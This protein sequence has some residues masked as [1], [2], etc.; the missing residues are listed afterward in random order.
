MDKRTLL[1][2]VLS[3]VIISVGFFLQGVLFPQ[4]KHPPQTVAA[5]ATESSTPQTATQAAPATLS[6]GEGRSTGT[7]PGSQGLAPITSVEPAPQDSAGLAEESYT[8][9]TNLVRV[10]FTSRGGAVEKFELLKEFDN[11]R[12]LEMING[13]T[14]GMTAFNLSFGGPNGPYTDALFHFKRV[15][16]TTYEFSRQFL[17]PGVNGQPPIPFLLTKTYIFHPNS[18]MLE[19]RITIQN[20]VNAVPNLTADG[21]AYTLQF[22]PQIGPYFAKMGENGEFRNFYT[23]ADGRRSTINPPNNGEKTF[24]QIVSWTSIVGKYFTVIAIP[25]ATKYAITYSHKPIQGVVE[26]SQLLF[27]R[28]PIESS[29]STSMFQFYVGPKDPRILT[30]FDDPTKN[31]FHTSGLQLEKVLDYTPLLG[32]LEDILNF[33]LRLFHRLVPNWGVSIIMLTVLIKLILYPFT[34][35]SFESTSKM[36]ALT[37]KLNELRERYKSNPTKLNQE[38]AALYKREGVSPL[39]GC[40]PLILQMPI[41]FALYGLLNTEFALRGATFIPGWITDLSQPESILHF[42]NFVIP[43]LGWTDLRALPFIY[44][45]SQLLTSKLMQAPDSQANK[46]MLMITYLMPIMF[47]FILYNVAS[48]L[49]VYWTVTNLLSAGQQIVMNQARRRKVALAG[50]KPPIPVRKPK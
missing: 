10:V 27:S 19:L 43:L 32:W 40:L 34:R 11:G 33:F 4:P 2:V 13:G 7:A 5:K 1:A 22:G 29:T 42:H 6:K 8:L 45:G 36:Q 23:Y 50:I 30:T 49:L 41:F 48:G 9:Q 20:S 47:F 3:V 24:K 26:T 14:S 37:P 46:N 18:Y 31:A 25:D 21:Y 39:G 44:V 16:A 15:D 28:P 38:M 17:A 12:P 35:K